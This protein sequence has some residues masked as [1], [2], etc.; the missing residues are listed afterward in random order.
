MKIRSPII[1]NGVLHH[2]AQHKLKKLNIE[3][4]QS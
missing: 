1:A 2:M 3:E 4:A